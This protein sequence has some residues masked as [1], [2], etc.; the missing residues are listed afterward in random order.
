[1]IPYEP[2]K[3]NRWIVKIPI[4]E[5]PEYC[6]SKVSPIKLTDNKWENITIEFRDLIGP[7]VQQVLFSQ[8]IDKGEDI[9]DGI[10]ISFLG[11]VGDEVAKWEIT[12]AQILS[13][14]FGGF[15]YASDEIRNIK[16]ILRPHKICCIF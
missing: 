9:I 16:M 7:S 1:M 14:D 11:P 12:R 15:D 6:V 10:I 5:I 3:V 13:I 8:I 2:K 4:L